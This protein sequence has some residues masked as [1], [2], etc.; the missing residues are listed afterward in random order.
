MSSFVT[1]SSPFF[2]RR[3]ARSWS[4]IVVTSALS[5]PVTWVPWCGV[6]MTLTKLRVIVS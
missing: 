2:S 5:K 3:A 1:F 6:A 4:L